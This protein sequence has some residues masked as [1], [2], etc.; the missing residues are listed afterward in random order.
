MMKKRGILAAALLGTAIVVSGCKKSETITF[1]QYSQYKEIDTPSCVTIGDYKGM[2]VS[3]DSFTVSDS[4]IASKLAKVLYEN[5]QYVDAPKKELASGDKVNISMTGYIDGKQNDGFTSDNYEFVY[6]EAEY[7]MDGF[8]ANLAGSYAGEVASFDLV[9]PSTFK[10]TQ[11][12]GQTVSFQ[13]TI[14]SVQE[15]VLPDL[16]DEFVKSISDSNTVDEYKEALIPVIKQDK[17]QSVRENTKSGVWQLVS[18]MSQVTEYPDAAVSTVNEKLSEVMEMYA[19]MYGLELEDYMTQYYGMT[20]DEYVK[21]A[22]KEEMLLDAIGRKE[23]ITLTEEEYQK[24]LSEYAASYG[25]NDT[26]AMVEKVGEDKIKQA[27]LWDKVKQYVSE[28]VTIAD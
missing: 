7:V 14:N 5:G 8:T 9:V 18:D 3:E 17:L 16:N 26:N 6:G 20:F 23:K 12:I 25:Y 1:D 4:D 24:G 10:E 22:V 15:Y 21:M 19:K 11:L 2:K 13:V 27:L 28:Q